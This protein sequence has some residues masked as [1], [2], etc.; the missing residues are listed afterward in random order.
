MNPGGGALS[1]TFCP[2]LG[3]FFRFSCGQSS[4]MGVALVL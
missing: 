4:A 1:M 3:P 2:G